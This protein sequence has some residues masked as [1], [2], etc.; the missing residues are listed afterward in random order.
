[1]NCFW[2]IDVIYL[3]IF[4]NGGQGNQQRTDLNAEETAAL[5]RLKEEDGKMDKKLNIIIDGTAQWKNNAL[6]IG[7]V[8]T[9]FLLGLSLIRKSTKLSTKLI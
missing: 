9:K 6:Q 1:M 3:D 7:Q 2:G 4:G 5:Q 8:S